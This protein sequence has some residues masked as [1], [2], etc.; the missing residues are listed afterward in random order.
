VPAGGEVT[1]DP[2]DPRGEHAETSHFEMWVNLANPRMEFIPGQRAWVRLTVG[3]RPLIW[4]GLDWFLQ[5]IETKNKQ[6]KWMQI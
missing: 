1:V 3:T 2:R 5:L 4:K 6:S